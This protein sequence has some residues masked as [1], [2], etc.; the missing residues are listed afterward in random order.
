MTKFGHLS[1]DDNLYARSCNGL[2]QCNLCVKKIETNQH[3]FYRTFNGNI[4]IDTSSINNII[5]IGKRSWSPI[6][7]LLLLLLLST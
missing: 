7:K 5:D 3:F 1:V 6:I 2:S 4:V